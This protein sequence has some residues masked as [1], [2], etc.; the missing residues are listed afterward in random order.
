MA[1]QNDQACLEVFF[2]R[3]GKLIGRDTFVMDGTQDDPPE[4]VMTGFVKQFYQSTP[5]VPKRILLQHKLE[6]TEEIQ[7]WLREKRG[8]AVA[9]RMAQRGPNR[10][11]VELAAANAEQQL[12]QIR[13]KWWS[14]TDALQEAM[15][16]LQEELNLPALPRTIECYDISNIQGSHPVGSMVTFEDG[17]PRTSRYR[18][19]KIKKVEGIDDYAMMQEMLRRRFKKLAQS[20]GKG[21]S[22]PN[23]VDGSYTEKTRPRLGQ[24]PGPGSSSTAGKGH[25]SAALEVFLELG[26][27]FIPLS[28]IAKENEWIF[29]PQTPEPIALSRR[30]PALHLVQRVRD[31]AHRFAITYHRKLRSKSSTQSSLDMVQGIGP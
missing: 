19:F 7:Q 21:V 9:I 22:G 17:A 31:E 23:G 10:R 24:D 12:S 11:L 18:R 14:N 16:E 4:R 30:S 26:I 15:T 5:F 29:V 1:T 27:D 6:E 20:H 13:V 2:V 28:S 3:N 8:G 25:L